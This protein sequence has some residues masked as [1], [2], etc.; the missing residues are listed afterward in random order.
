VAGANTDASGNYTLSGL[1]EGGYIVKTCAHCTGLSYVDKYYND[2]Y[3]RQDAD[4][5]TVAPPGDTGGINFTMETPSLTVTRD[6]PPVVTP[7]TTFDVTITFSAPADDFTAIGLTDFAPTGWTVTVNTAWCTP[8]PMDCLATNNRADYIWGGPYTVGTSFTAVYQVTVPS[9]A[10]D[11]TYD[12][13]NGVLE[14]YLG[15]DGPYTDDVMGDYQVEVVKGAVIEGLTY[16]VK[17]VILGG[18]TI[19]LD[20]DTFVVSDDGGFYQII[21]TTTGEHTVVAS[22]DGFR[23][24]TRTINITNIGGTYTLDFKAVYGLV[25]NAPNVSYVLAC[26]HKWKFPPEGLGLTVSKVLSVIHAWKFPI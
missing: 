12:F 2:A 14:Y 13:T 21:A 16:E 5:V 11:G 8:T 1:P 10:A 20:G 7:G 6:L 3:S 19:T 26:I 24:Q 4:S 23:S 18:V 25:P 15:Y 9:D 22:K 17:G